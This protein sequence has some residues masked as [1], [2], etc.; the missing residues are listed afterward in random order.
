MD[1]KR[2]IH[3]IVASLVTG[4]LERTLRN[5]LLGHYGVSSKASDVTSAAFSAA[6]QAMEDRI[7]DADL[8]AGDRAIKAARWS[9]IR[10]IDSYVPAGRN[11]TFRDCTHEQYSDERTF[12]EH[13]K[14]L[15]RSPEYEDTILL[16]YS[17][18]VDSVRKPLDSEW[19]T[20]RLEDFSFDELAEVVSALER[21]EYDV[22]AESS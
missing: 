18:H 10:I 8:K 17:D 11:L 21:G 5:E 14:R 7:L 15:Y 13:F 19:S 2:K 3:N 6:R 1:N 16:E 12:V 4:P 20:T 22:I 9:L